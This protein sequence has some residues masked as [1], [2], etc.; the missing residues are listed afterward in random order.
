MK[1][2]L[3]AAGGTMGHLG[4]ALAV[5]REVKRSESASVITFVGT[6][7]GIESTIKIEFPRRS[8][9]KVPLPRKAGIG[10]LLFPL[11]L[12][13]AILQAI[14]R[15]GRADTVVGFGGYV[16]T[17]IYI[18]ARLLRRRIILHE[19]NALPGFA[20]RLGRSL[21]AE[22]FANFE[23]VGKSW[24]CPVIGMPLPEEIIEL[25]KEGVNRPRNESAMQI[26][27]MGGSQGS[28]RIN[29]VIWAALPQL[30]K[31][32]KILHAVGVNNMAAL[33][34]KLSHQGYQ[35][36]GYIDSMAEAYRFADLVIARAGA[37]TCAE[38][39][40]LGKRAIL[41]PL[42]HGNGEQSF[43][44]RALVERGLAV[45]VDD[46]RFDSHWL[47]ANIEKALGLKLESWE[48]PH[49][50][51]REILAESILSPK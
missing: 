24:G 50:E 18:A 42:G 30:D 46:A 43:N 28:M 32:L 19:A 41:I 4:P 13:L 44:A 45:S 29:K 33:P 39:L 49:L 10:V 11:K 25:A 48:A 17:P 37:V 3:F 27:V 1:R 26:L 16:A 36:V 14:P 8:I 51:A 2:I 5:A 6:S 15:V 35:A 12:L 38:L 9:I 20:N 21:G 22:C 47:I 40:A 34:S 23:S 7:S 31:K